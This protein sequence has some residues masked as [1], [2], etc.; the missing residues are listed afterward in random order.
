MKAIVRVLV[1]RSFQ[2]T[3][4]NFFLKAIPLPSTKCR[5]IRKGFKKIKNLYHSSTIVILSTF[6]G[7]PLLSFLI[8]GKYTEEIRSIR[9][10]CF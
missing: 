2:F 3:Y 5:K 7:I 6:Y 9:H 4:F 8:Q 1:S 10:P